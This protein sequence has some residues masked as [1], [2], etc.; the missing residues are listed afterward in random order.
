MYNG[1]ILGTKGS[2]KSSIFEHIVNNKVVLKNNS[3]DYYKVRRITLNES[4]GNNKEF[5]VRLYDLPP[6]YDDEKMKKFL[7]S[8]DFIIY[9]ID[10][11]YSNNIDKINKYIKSL[12]NDYYSGIGIKILIILNKDDLFNDKNIEK[13]EFVEE[14]KLDDLPNNVSILPLRYSIKNAENNDTI[15][16]TLKLLLISYC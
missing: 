6:S 9:V 3:V 10:N 13:K 8:K 15:L 1:I 4:Y 12:L 5:S 2:G 7:P 11:N 16:E 14:L